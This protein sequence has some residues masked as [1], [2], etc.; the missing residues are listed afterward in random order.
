MS[1]PIQITIDRPQATETPPAASQAPESQADRRV[2]AFDLV[3]AT[4]WAITPDMLDTIR[5][6][7]IREG[8]GV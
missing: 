1:T 7:S 5:S 3:A 6:I 2:S 8:E 4:P